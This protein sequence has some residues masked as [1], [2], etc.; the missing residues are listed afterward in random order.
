MNNKTII[1]IILMLTSIWSVNAF[2]EVQLLQETMSNTATAT[3]T[4]G[5]KFIVTNISNTYTLT[6]AEFLS[7]CTVAYLEDVSHSI[8]ETAAITNFNA[9]FSTPLVYGTS[10]YITCNNATNPYTVTYEA[11]GAFPYSMSMISWTGGWD[12]GYGDDVS[13]FRNVKSIT[14]EVTPFNL[15]V[16]L[17]YN[18]TGDKTSEVNQA[19]GTSSDYLWS[20]FTPTAD[21]VLTN[22]SINFY[23]PIDNCK[24]DLYLQILD[25]SSTLLTQSTNAFIRNDSIGCDLG[26]NCCQIKSTDNT[27]MFD[28]QFYPFNMT[29]NTTYRLFLIGRDYGVMVGIAPIT[30]ETIGFYAN[31]GDLGSG[32]ISETNKQMVMEIYGDGEPTPTPPVFDCIPNWTCS[33]YATCDYTGYQSCN[34]VTDLNTCGESYTGDY[35]EFSPNFCGTYITEC[36][37]LSTPDGIYLLSNNIGTSGECLRVTAN[38]I[39]INGQGYT[40][41]GT[42]NALRT[43]S[44]IGVPFSPLTIYDTIIIED[45]LAYGISP[46]SPPNGKAGGTVTLY[47]TTV[48][49]ILAYGSTYP[50]GGVGGIITAT[51]SLIAVADAKAGNSGFYFTCRNGVSGGTIT[52][53]NTYYEQLYTNGGISSC[54]GTTGPDG[55]QTINGGC[56]YDW[57]RYYI[58]STCPETSQWT[59]YYTDLGGCGLPAPVGNSTLISCSYFPPVYTNQTFENK[60]T[61]DLATVPDISAVEDF[62]VAT[63][64]SAVEFTTTVDLTN[65]TNI[66]EVLIMTGTVISIDSVAAPQLNTTADVILSVPVAADNQCEDFLLYYAPGFYTTERDIINHGTVIATNANIGTDCND[67]S[68]CTNVQCTNGILTFTAQRF[69]GFGLG[70]LTPEAVES[71]QNTRATIF[72]AFGLIAL[73]IIVGAAFLIINLIKGDGFDSSVIIAAV[74]GFIAVAI[75]VFVGYLIISQVSNSVCII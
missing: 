70:I 36:G 27:S 20:S 44:N 1:F 6:S 11:M 31:Y 32:Y 17:I 67:P 56:Q 40:I 16:S 65:V 15:N 29:A 41:S 64:A 74:I 26:Y 23:A 69:S 58:P 68:I 22:I 52:L 66:G 49:D 4:W 14:L 8:L 12:S 63:T 42:I 55:V 13:Y 37:T 51:D 5:M 2:S 50:V 43:I 7:D 75:V 38:N 18:N 72:A 53:T 25:E 46:T 47:N 30:G 3:D 28:Y 10:Y 21:F 61:T 45:I 35:T 57:I 54:G 73:F 62:T 71:C 24:E 34:A 60:T 39:I 59:Q 48:R 19:D 33:G 9:T